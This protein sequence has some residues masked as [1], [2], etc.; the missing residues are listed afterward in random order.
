MR[1]L[2][3]LLST[4]VG[5]SA[6][7]IGPLAP[8]AACSGNTAT[9]RSDWCDYN[10]DTDYYTVA[11]DTGVTRE[12]YFNLEQ[13]TVAPDGYS[14]IAYAV[15][16]SIPGPTIIADWGDTVVVHVTN[17][18]TA[19]ENGTSIHFHGVRQNY[20]NQMDGVTSITQCPT[21]PGDTITYTWQATQ[22]GSSWYH[23]HI[24]LQAWE[25]VAGGILINGPAS[26]NY[27]EDLGV[28]LLS[29]WSHQTV[30]ELYSS[31]LITGPPTLTNGLI[32]GTNTWTDAD[33]NTVG[34]R[35]NTSFTSGSTYLFRLVNVAIDTYFKFSID[36]HTMTVIAADFVP[37]V[38]YNT[39][40]LD[41]TMGKRLA[42]FLSRPGLILFL[43]QRYDVIVSADQES[44][45]DNF[46][47]RAV[48]QAACSDNDNADDI[49]GIVY[50]GDEAETPTTTA[51]SYTDACVD[52]SLDDLVPYLAL[53]ASDDFWSD[54]EEVDIDPTNGILLWSVN[55]TSFH[56]EW[57]N[58]TL[59]QLYNNDTSFNTTNHVIQLNES[60]E[61]AYII[62]QAENAVPHP[63]HLHGHDFYILAQG[64]GTFNSSDLVSLTNPTRRDVANLPGS[65]YL[66]IAFKT[67]NPGAWLAHCHIGW[68]TEQGLAFQFVEQY[69][70]ARE[71]IDYD[72][73]SSNC[74]SW[75]TYA[76]DDDVSQDTY[77]DGI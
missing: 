25:G 16:G 28:L 5:A 43:G 7:I 40:V 51:Y 9:T 52:E 18:L 70:A 49:R 57:T 30:D 27:D 34:Y 47:M 6:G 1:F 29:D 77:D 64:T 15:N 61:W 32:N 41:I 60:N 76:G 14:R 42:R 23:S 21:P 62:I 26:S 63:I 8:R 53:S 59:L 68:H 19:A 17:S 31:S 38:P 58:P 72:F 10:L 56:T 37:I 36:N 11:P 35:F 33:N 74:D 66:V 4:A 39:T 3:L 50:Y 22:Y 67:D 75:S 44:V 24:G 12:Y 65:G 69:S 2:S 13:V 46:W 48:P 20:T 71:L 45:A 54:L 55:D 73:L